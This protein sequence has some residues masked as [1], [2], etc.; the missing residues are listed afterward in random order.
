MSALRL[1]DEKQSRCKCDRKA[2][3][4]S[5]ALGSMVSA[6]IDFAVFIGTYL[7]IHFFVF[8]GR[9]LLSGSKAESQA[10]AKCDKGQRLHSVEVCSAQLSRWKQWALS[11][12]QRSLVPAPVWLLIVKALC[13]V[14]ATSAPAAPYVTWHSKAAKQRAIWKWVSRVDSDT[15]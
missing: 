2:S 6:E 12:W 14:N 15:L 11:A 7:S 10:G 9:Y 5:A 13:A 3:N 4:S 1:Q 8:P